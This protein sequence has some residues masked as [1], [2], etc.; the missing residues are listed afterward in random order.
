[1][2]NSNFPNGFTVIANNSGK[3]TVGQANWYYVP[4]SDG[5]VYS[6][7]DVVKSAAGGD[8]NGVPAVQKATGASSEYVRGVVVGV[9]PVPA[10]G[11]PSLIGTPLALEN[12]QVPASKTAGWYV[13]VN[14]DP[15][16]IFSIQDDGLNPGTTVA[17]ACN[18]NAG[19][20][21]TNPTSPQQIS[22]TVLTS[23]TI[24]TSATLP[25]KIMGLVLQNAPGG[26]NSYGAYAKWK[27]KFNLHELN[28]GAAG[29]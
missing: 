9:A 10:I 6:I 17:S 12:I 19:Y 5:S 15:D 11:T 1:M 26:G 21:P 13:M 3:A 7:G 23:S 27:V 8:A 18:K 24:G 22:A 4:S 28:G 16:S 2:A 29:V 14:D 20:T 25:L